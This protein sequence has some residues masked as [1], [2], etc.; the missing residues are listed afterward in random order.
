MV[1]INL[2]PVKEMKQRVQARQQI[3]AFI[4]VFL[5]VISGLVVT[6]LIQAASVSRLENELNTLRAEKKKYEKQIAEIKKIEKNRKLLEK[7]IDIIKRLERS[8][9]LTV[10]VMDEVAAATPSDRMWLLSMSQAGGRLS[11]SGV[12]LDNRTIASYMESLKN[13]S[14]I[15]DVTLSSVSG[16]SIAGRKLKSFSMTCAVAP[17]PVDSPEE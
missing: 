8:S 13:K 7:R 12:A 5:C 14:Y 15:K 11:L 10:H 16:K 6:G 4:F 3:I 17:P 2:L 9:A 1:H